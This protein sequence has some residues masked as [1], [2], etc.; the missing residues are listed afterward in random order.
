M[1]VFREDNDNNQIIGFEPKLVKSTITFNGKNNRVVC[2][3]DITIQNSKLAFQGDN[4]ILYLSKPRKNYVLHSAI[5][6]N[7]VL[8]FDENVTT[9]GKLA[10]MLSEGKNV[11]IGKNCLF[12]FGIWFRVAD[13]HLIYDVKTKNRISISD[14]IYLGDHV[15]IGQNALILK[16]TQVGSGSIIGANAV[17]SNKKIKSNTTVGGNPA[18]EI[19]SDVFWDVRTSHRFTPKDSEKFSTYSNDNWIYN[20][21]ENTIDFN[22]IENTLNSIKDVDK[23]V[24]YLL[25]LR[26]NKNKNRFYM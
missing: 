22:D 12:S 5:Y 10:V 8:F 11:F 20:K 21:D 2:E 7:S 14:S 9:N 13:P 25:S 16:G 4:S 1:D 24:D 18:K 6:S 17:V 19:R 3:E 26:N 15:W 23:K